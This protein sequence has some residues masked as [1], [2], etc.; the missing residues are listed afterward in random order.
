MHCKALSRREKANGFSLVEMTMAMAIFL[1]AALAAYALYYAGTRSFK[2]AENATSLQQNARVG[3]DLM[4]REI[5]LAGFNYNVDGASARPDEQV[6]GAWDTAVTVRGDF[7]FEDPTL[8]VTPESTLDG[9]FNEVSVGNDEIVTFALGKPTLPTASSIAFVGDVAEVPRDGDEESVSIPGPVLLQDDP[10]YTLYRVTPKNVA[11]ITGFDG[12]FDDPAEFDYEPLAEDIKDLTFRYFDGAGNL[13]TPATPADTTDDLGGAD[14]G[15]NTRARIS[16]IEVHLEAMTPDPDPQWIDPTDTNPATQNHRK[17]SLTAMVTPRNAGMKGIPDL[18][19]QPPSTPTG[20]AACVGHCGGVVLTWNANSAAE[21][22]SQYTVAYGTTSGNLNITRSSGTNSMF[23]GSLDPTG[24]Y[25]FSIRAE[26]PSGNTSAFSSEIN[27]TNLNNTVPDIVGGF[28]AAGS[29]TQPGI[30]LNWTPLSANDDAI[31]GASGAGGCDF[32]KPVNRDLGGYAL[33]RAVGSAPGTDPATAYAGPSTLPASVNQYVDTQV[34]ACRT[35]TYDILALDACSVPGAPQAA[36]INGSY[37]TSVVPAAPQNVNA[38]NSGPVQNTIVW[39]AVTADANGAAINVAGYNIYRAVGPIGS[40]P[41][42]PTSY[43]STPIGTSST[44]TF[45]DQYTGSNAP[46]AGSIFYYRISAV[47]DCP[48]ESALSAPD[49]ASCAFNGQVL[50]DPLDSSTVLG[51]VPITLSSD[52]TDTYAYG[53]VTVTDSSGTVVFS[54]T[55]S[56]YPF[57]FSWNSLSLTP[58]IYTITGQITN[59]GGCSKTS[60]VNVVMISPAACCLSQTGLSLQSDNKA[61][62][63]LVVRLLANLCDNNLNVSHIKVTFNVASSLL[64]L[65][66]VRWNGSSITTG[67]NHTSPF[68]QDVTVFVPSVFNGGSEQTIVFDF[69]RSLAP[70]D[71]VSFEV[72]YSGDVVGQQICTFNVTIS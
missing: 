71:T 20:L 49:G 63:D 43:G 53:D 23:I 19:L 32:N 48:N 34:V 67:V 51:I 12:T 68:D 42:D 37:S 65:D 52:G 26:D 57:T 55:S 46:P 64:K 24:T 5:R 14:A 18:D 41:T 31:A 11:D 4:V 29:T 3:F 62:S 54:A 59:I 60:S 44:T 6:E 28:T 69:D 13:L 72:T 33:F 22:V 35:Y 25:Y 1:V 30:A 27:A 9:T 40:P 36:T 70:G 45:V 15:R 2:K 8:S 21:L 61:N 10:P 38:S 66:E 50:L 17:V 39:D 47:D 58:G 7:D 16:R 56:T